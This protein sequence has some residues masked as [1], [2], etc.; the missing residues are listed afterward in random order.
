[1]KNL[2]DKIKMYSRLNAAKYYSLVFVQL[3]YKKSW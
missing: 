2:C 3:Y 1:M